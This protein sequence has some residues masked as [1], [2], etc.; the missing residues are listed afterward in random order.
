MCS[1]LPD[2]ACGSVSAYCCRSAARAHCMSFT[3]LSFDEFSSRCLFSFLRADV[4]VRACLR[5]CVRVYVRAC[6]CMCARACVPVF[7]FAMILLTLELIFTLRAQAYT[8]PQQ[9]GQMVLAVS[10]FA[11][12]Y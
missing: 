12:P 1:V 4:C 3:L 2:A 6:V 10:H 8:S 7:F 9:H 5:A 11:P